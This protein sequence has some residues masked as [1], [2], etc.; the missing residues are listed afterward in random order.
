VP[1]FNINNMEQGRAILK[2]AAAV[3]APAILQASRARAYA[4]DITLRFMVEALAEMNP[5][6]PICLH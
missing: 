1:A 6:I 3:D 4:G 5:G 2:A